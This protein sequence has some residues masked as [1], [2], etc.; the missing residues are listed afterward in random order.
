VLVGRSGVGE[1]PRPP[2]PPA[3]PYGP[4]PGPGLRLA[5]GGGPSAA[6]TR[7]YLDNVVVF[8]GSAS[9]SATP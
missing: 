8:A 9:R 5:T 1:S 3:L 7:H 6:H 2:S 4:R